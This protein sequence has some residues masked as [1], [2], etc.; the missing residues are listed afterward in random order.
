[1]LTPST[2]TVRTHPT[3]RLHGVTKHGNTALIF[4]TL[5]QG[6]HNVT[7]RRVRVTIGSIEKQQLLHISSMSGFKHPACKAHAPYYSVNCGLIFYH[8]CP[9]YKGADKS[10]A[11]TDISYVKINPLN[12]E[13]NPICH[14]LAL[15][16]T[17]HI[18]HVSGV[19][20]KY[21][22]CLSSL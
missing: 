8:I 11:R 13:L 14:L 9:Y 4:T 10:L 12:A 2:W 1:M 21:V 15:L 22:S 17:H 18:L 5:M 19:R 20:V 16:G 3:A 6:T 7:L